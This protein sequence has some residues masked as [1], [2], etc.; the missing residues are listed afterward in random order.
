M[1]PMYEGSQTGYSTLGSSKPGSGISHDL[2]FAEKRMRQI[3]ERL[4]T[5]GNRI[6]GSRPEAATSVPEN[7]REISVTESIRQV[8]EQI[9]RAEELLTRIEQSI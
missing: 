1:N 8:N 7:P 2:T 6:A 9:T 3:N 5:V 4:Y